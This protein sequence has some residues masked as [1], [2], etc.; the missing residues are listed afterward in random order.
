MGGY[1]FVDAVYIDN[2]MTFGG[3]AFEYFLIENQTGIVIQI[4]LTT[5][6]GKLP[7]HRRSV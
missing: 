1:L 6:L 5:A 7:R 4:A 3:T 2:A